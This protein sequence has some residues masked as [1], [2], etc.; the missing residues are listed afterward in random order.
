MQFARWL[1][2]LLVLVPVMTQAKDLG[3]Q[4]KTYEIIE[5]DIRAVIMRQMSQIDKQAIADKLKKSTENYTDDL[6]DYPL[7][8]IDSTRTYHVNIEVTTQKP[9]YRPTLNEQGQMEWKVMV[10]KGTKVNPLKKVRPYTAYL[11]FNGQSEQQREFARTLWKAA[12]NYIIPMMSAGDPAD[13]AKEIDAPVYRASPFILKRFDL[14]NTPALARAGQGQHQ[15]QIAVT[16]F[17]PPYGLQRALQ[18][19]EL[20]RMFGRSDTGDTKP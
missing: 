1:I 13:M 10:E 2:A 11:I 16:E 7:G 14:E 8:T 12:P 3:V 6:P 4:G 19:I 18:H 15:Y 20:R 5:P 9:I 17:A